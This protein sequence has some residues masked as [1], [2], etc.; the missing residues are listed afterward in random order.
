MLQYDWQP[1]ISLFS[2]KLKSVKTAYGF[3]RSRSVYLPEQLVGEFLS[4]RAVVFHLERASA[5]DSLQMQMLPERLRA[6]WNPGRTGAASQWGH[7]S[8]EAV[9]V[10]CCDMAPLALGEAPESTVLP[11]TEECEVCLSLG[12]RDERAQSGHNPILMI[13]PSTCISTS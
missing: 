6:G 11:R 13:L 4:E 5:I 12:D 1:P 2:E 3:T 7:C 8:Q 10:Q 9:L